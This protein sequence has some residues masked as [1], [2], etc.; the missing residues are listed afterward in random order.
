MDDDRPDRSA[1]LIDV[2]EEFGCHA[3]C[4][5]SLQGS[6][7]AKCGAICDRQNR[8]ADDHVEDGR[9]TFDPCEDHGVDEGRGFGVRAVG[10]EEDVGVRGDDQAQ[11][12][13]VDDV[14]EAAWS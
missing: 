9:K 6:C 2:Y 13:E 1:V 8:Q 4:C 7:A 11:N 12:E 14:K 5:Q 10:V 3:L